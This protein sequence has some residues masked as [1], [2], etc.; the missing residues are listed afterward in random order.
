MPKQVSAGF[1]IQTPQGFLQCH[2]TG[3]PYTGSNYDL[4]KGHVEDGESPLE[5]AHRELKE[6]TGLILPE[7]FK[8]IDCGERPYTSAKRLHVFYV[9][10]DY[11]PDI[12]K[13]KCTSMFTRPD[14]KDIPEM[15]DYMFSFDLKN[16]YTSMQR[17]LENIIK[18]YKIEL[19][20]Y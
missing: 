2:P 6:E 17:V 8:I 1:L 7:G 18:E 5:A 14:G 11:V 15:N 9:K 13:M 3:R 19:D 12:R 10:L 16:Y 4:P 20:N